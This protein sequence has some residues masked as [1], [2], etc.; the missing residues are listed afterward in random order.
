M[1]APVNLQS[2]V[3]L[4]EA[5]SPATLNFIGY[6]TAGAL[7]TTT[8]ADLTA[9]AVAAV[10]PSV[11]ASAASASAASS[12]ASAAAASA[13]A[14]SDAGAAAGTTAGT[15]AAQAVVAAGNIATIAALRA[16]A[17]A[18]L[19]SGY[20]VTVR[21]YYAD[22]DGGGGV[23]LWS[24]T[25]T[26]A[27]NTGTVIRPTALTSIQ[28]GR[29]VRVMFGLP[30]TPQMFGAKCDNTN[31][32]AVAIQAA[33]N[34]SKVLWFPPATYTCKTQ[35]VI[36]NTVSRWVGLSG[37]YPQS[38]T[39]P[40]PRLFYH[41]DLGS[42]P[43]I[44]NQ[45]STAFTHLAFRGPEKGT[46]TALRNRRVPGDISYEDTDVTVFGC[47]FTEWDI[48]VEH[49]NRG[50]QFVNNTVAACTNAVRMYW[51]DENFLED[52]AN[53]YDGLPLGFRAIR[54]DDN[55]FHLLTNA[56][57]NIGDNA[58]YLRGFHMCDNTLD[59]G[60]RL[61]LGGLYS[62][63]ISDNT[64]DQTNASAI[65]FTTAVQDVKIEGNTFCGDVSPRSEPTELIKF[66]YACGDFAIN[67]NTF[68]N[69]SLYGI[70]FSAAVVG[71]TINGNNFAE[72]GTAGTAT[73]AC[74]RFVTD[75]QDVAINGNSF[76]PR[77]DAR[78]IRGTSTATWAGMT[79][80]GNT[81]DRTKAWVTSYINGADNSIQA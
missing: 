75:A 45:T 67:G 1:N 34:A 79:I 14:A 42:E 81:R 68:R 70:L 63:T 22:H 6:T 78:A 74:I 59:A 36:T 56:V 25:S 20:G 55:R 53:P 40:G 21:G 5:T 73:A 33:S 71:G 19:T 80:Q 65:E 31:D 60:D 16:V 50:L 47:N 76:K 12:S 52:E 30:P 43:M 13:S 37:Q 10:A 72:I 26:A 46:G 8:G 24:S 32:D 58:E 28:A 29:W 9:S 49:W 64:V 61:F 3:D 35:I 57:V 44:V 51:D 77:T 38:T 23:Y 11:A 54:I 39:V 69:A 4:P 17:H 66:G 2:V 15:T 27:D 48:A 7:Q 41:S 62:G 18:S